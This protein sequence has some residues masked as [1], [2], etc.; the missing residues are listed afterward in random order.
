[1]RVSVW[2]VKSYVRIV[3]ETGI[4]ILRDGNGAG[5]SSMNGTWLY[6]DEF[7]PVYDQLTFKAGQTLFEIRVIS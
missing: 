4:W 2:L 7:H 5:K 3:Y 1:M 6:A